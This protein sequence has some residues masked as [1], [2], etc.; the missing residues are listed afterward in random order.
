MSFVQVIIFSSTTLIIVVVS[1][2]Y[3]CYCS[4]WCQWSLLFLLCIAKNYY[5]SLGCF[6]HLK[7]FC[8][9]EYSDAAYVLT[10]VWLV[11][12]DYQ[13]RLT[14]TNTHT[15]LAL[16]HRH[17]AHNACCLSHLL[18]TPVYLIELFYHYTVS[19]K[20]IIFRFCAKFYKKQ[21]NTKHGVSTTRILYC[22][23]SWKSFRK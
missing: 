11:N 17:S 7:C 13:C 1:C 20:T 2:Y 3:Y 23:D 12:E 9:L 22:N 5:N 8:K 4:H 14:N 10:I 19:K 15:Q 6:T 18:D 16:P 21:Y